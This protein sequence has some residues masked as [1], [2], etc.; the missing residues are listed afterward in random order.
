MVPKMKST[1]PESYSIISRNLIL[2]LKYG[3]PH[4]DLGTSKRDK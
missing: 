1:K 3:R 4:G 2:V